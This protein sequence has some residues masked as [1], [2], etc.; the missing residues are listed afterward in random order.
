MPYT[1]T[2]KCDAHWDQNF[3]ATG[4]AGSWIIKVISHKKQ[5][6]HNLA[7]KGVKLERFC[8]VQLKTTFCQ[9]YNGGICN[10]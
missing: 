10:L 3:V 2:P 7:Y 6:I 1:Q 9:H 5:L 8:T 4:L